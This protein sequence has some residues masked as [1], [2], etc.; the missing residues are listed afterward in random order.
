M[1]AYMVLLFAITLVLGITEILCGIDI[2]KI[3]NFPS[4]IFGGFALVVISATFIRGTFAEEP[5]AYFYVG[6]LILLVF[7][8]LYVLVL[9]ANAL[10]S[11]ILGEEFDLLSNLRPEMPISL[12]AIPGVHSVLKKKETK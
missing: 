9:L 12:L 10:D 4:D 11:V 3:N 1:K 5:V 7:G 6:S 8:V 2:V